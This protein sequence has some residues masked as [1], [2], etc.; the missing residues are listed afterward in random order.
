MFQRGLPR[1][2]PSVTSTRDTIVAPSLLAAD[3]TQLG[4]EIRRVEDAGADWL[5]LD[6]MD[7]QFVD[8]I[9]FGPAVVAMVRKHNAA[10]ARR[11]PDDPAAGSLCAALH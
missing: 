8:N 4:D 7:G 6:I 11:S 10:A 2:A 3:F 1:F 9:S 5:H